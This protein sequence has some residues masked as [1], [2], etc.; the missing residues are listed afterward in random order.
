MLALCFMMLYVCLFI[1]GLEYLQIYE[2]KKN[3][4]NI[5]AA[6]S[7]RSWKCVVEATSITW[8]D[9]AVGT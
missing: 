7:L 5:L 1:S 4:T 6:K 8:P 9:W 2:E 3:A